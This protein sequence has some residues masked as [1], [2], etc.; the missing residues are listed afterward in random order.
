MPL[1][2]L[3]VHPGQGLLL[4]LPPCVQVTFIPASIFCIS[5]SFESMAWN[6]GPGL[7]PCG[8]GG[9]LPRQLRVNSWHSHLVSCALFILPCRAPRKNK[10]SSNPPGVAQAMFRVP[11]RAPRG[12]CTRIRRAVPQAPCTGAWSPCLILLCRVASVAREQAL[13]PREDH[14]LKLLEVKLNELSKD[15]SSLT[16][17]LA[18]HHVLTTEQGFELGPAASGRAARDHMSASQL[19]AE[20][21]CSAQQHDSMVHRLPSHFVGRLFDS[22]SCCLP[23]SRPAL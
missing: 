22:R 9:T 20:T 16:A 15:D 11:R 10:V 13:H 14:R 5:A 4:S 17:Q 18:G 6:S 8:R 21:P 23:T 7:R 3:P 1:H 19:L 2:S 12:T